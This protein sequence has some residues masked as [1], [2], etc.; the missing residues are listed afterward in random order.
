MESLFFNRIFGAGRFRVAGS[1]KV[2][3][4]GN[5]AVGGWVATTKAGT[6]S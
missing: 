1:V 2:I 3:N 4:Q 5:E 6:W